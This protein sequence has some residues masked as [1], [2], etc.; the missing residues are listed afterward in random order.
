L[1]Q[2]D[3][4]TDDQTTPTCVLLDDARPTRV[5]KIMQHQHYATPKIYVEEAQRLWRLEKAEDAGTQI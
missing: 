5:Q 2:G 4:G 1:K 3:N